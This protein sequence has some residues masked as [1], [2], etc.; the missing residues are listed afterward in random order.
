MTGMHPVGAEDP[1]AGAE[2][3]FFSGTPESLAPRLF[4]L[5]HHVVER[6]LWALLL[7][8]P[9]GA[10]IQVQERA[11]PGAAMGR[12]HAW[13]GTDLGIL[14]AHLMTLLPTA[15]YQSVRSALFAHGTYTDLGAVPCPPTPR[16]AFGHPLKLRTAGTRVR[17]Y[18][19]AL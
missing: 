10:H 12:V 6:T 18:V 13:E 17:A 4:A 14:P 3:H 2:F 1:A 7:Q 11:E 16:G 9:E 15:S 19:L 5:P 8:D